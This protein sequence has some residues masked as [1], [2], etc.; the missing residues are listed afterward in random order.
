MKC[1]R[2]F[3]IFYFLFFHPKFDTESVFV[4]F[5]CLLFVSGFATT[6]LGA[7]ILVNMTKV[8][9]DYTVVDVEVN[10]VST[11]VLEP[12]GVMISPTDNRYV[13]IGGI[14]STTLAVLDISSFWNAAVVNTRANVGA[15]LVGATWLDQPN[16]GGFSESLVYMACWGYNGGLMVLDTSTNPMNPP[17]VARSVSYA[18][19]QANRVKLDPSGKFAYLPLEQELGGVA[20]FDIQQVQNLGKL[21]LNS[22][23]HVPLSEFHN[24]PGGKLVQSTK[25]YCLAVAANKLFMFIAETASVYIYDIA[26]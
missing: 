24:G 12:E 13:Y 2:L 23:A 7:V 26:F 19:S 15:Q 21:T 1:A 25:T 5:I 11:P 16:Q 14:T 8:L 20:V 4:L 10:V 18:T 17:E 6:T 22:T 3:F 9:S